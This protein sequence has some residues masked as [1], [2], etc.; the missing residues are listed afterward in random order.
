M[1]AAFGLGRVCIQRNQ[2]IAHAR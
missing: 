2:I 1:I